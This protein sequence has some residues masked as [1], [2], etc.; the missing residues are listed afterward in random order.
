MTK[1]L[2]YYM[3]LPYRIVILPPDDDDDTW[4]A[5]LPELSGCNTYAETWE[6]LQAMIQDAKRTWISFALEDGRP[7]PEPVPARP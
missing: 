4:F 2:N 5:E 6:E 1:S 7:I 3:K